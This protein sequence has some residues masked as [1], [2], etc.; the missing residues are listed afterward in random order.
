MGAYQYY[1]ERLSNAKKKDTFDGLLRDLLSVYVL[2]SSLLTMKQ[3]QA[4]QAQEAA[5]TFMSMAI[6]CHQFLAPSS[7]VYKAALRYGERIL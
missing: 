1:L 4:G 6:G 2:D 7:G 3:I 5:Q